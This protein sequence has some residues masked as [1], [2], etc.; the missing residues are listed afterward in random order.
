MPTLRD[1]SLIKPGEKFQPWEEGDSHAPMALSWKKSWT[2]KKK[3]AENKKFVEIKKVKDA[4]AEANLAKKSNP[5]ET[6]Q[7]PAQPTTK[8]NK[9]TSKKSSKEPLKVKMTFKKK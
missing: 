5:T 9:N 4:E 1:R 8:K 6:E 7:K 2:K 3:K